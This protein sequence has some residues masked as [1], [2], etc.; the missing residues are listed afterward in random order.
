[1]K[2]RIKGLLILCTVLCMGFILSACGGVSNTENATAKKTV[3]NESID[4]KDIDWNVDTRIIDGEK[5]LS[6]NYT[7]KS[8]F[9]VI[10]V[11]MKFTQK[12]G[13]SKKKLKVLK[14]MENAGY[15]LE[16]I[17]IIGYNSKLTEPGET[18]E[19][20]MCNFNDTSGYF[21]NKIKQF[22][23]ME[24]NEVRIKFIGS[25]GLIH[26][27]GYD[28]INNE[29]LKSN[30]TEK[31]ITWI[32]NEYSKMVPKPDAKVIQDTAMIEDG[33][34]FHFE[35]LGADTE[36]FNTYIKECKKKG[37]TKN[38]KEYERSWSGENSEKYKLSIEYWNKYE[39][40]NC[41]LTKIE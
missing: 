39:K 31:A 40:M 11:D 41:D 3:L 16:D 5:C 38:L 15:N 19:D 6:F 22:E 33:K 14:S 30:D 37:F 9:D 36:T 21:P 18:V 32:D 4:I 10:E 8:K 28:Y 7:N 17:Y 26:S 1:M 27:C 13:L 34:T 23:I 29:Y 2:T 12:V 25:D 24:P 35:I 20:S